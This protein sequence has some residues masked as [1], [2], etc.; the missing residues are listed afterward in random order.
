MI[1][2][3][4]IKEDKYDNSKTIEEIS[5]LASGEDEKTA[6]FMATYINEG[7]MTTLAGRKAGFEVAKSYI[8]VPSVLL[9]FPCH[10][11]LHFQRYL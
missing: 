11:P 5:Y 4:Y 10:L 1:S 2:F 9:R 6:G 3:I 7:R 8:S